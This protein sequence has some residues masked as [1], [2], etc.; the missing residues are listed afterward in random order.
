MKTNVD[1]LVSY[2]IGTSFCK[3]YCDISYIFYIGDLIRMYGCVLSIM[4]CYLSTSVLRF[5]VFY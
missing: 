3:Y 2:I 5:S 1:L 4:R